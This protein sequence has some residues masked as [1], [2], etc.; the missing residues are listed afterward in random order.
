MKKNLVAIETATILVLIG[1]L[2]AGIILKIFTL[3]LLPICLLMIGGIGIAI[4]K[5]IE[6][7]KD[8]SSKNDSENSNNNGMICAILTIMAK[9][10]RSLN[11]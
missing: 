3:I 10:K 1:V 11:F 6:L 8:L 7:R 9:L 4:Y 5:I 2:I